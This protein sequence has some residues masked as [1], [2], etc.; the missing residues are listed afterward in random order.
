MCIRDRPGPAQTWFQSDLSHPNWT[1]THRS[2]WLAAGNCACG[3]LSIREGLINGYHSTCLWPQSIA[4]WL[5]GC[6]F[7]LVL[8]YTCFCANQDRVYPSLVIAELYSKYS[9]MVLGL[10]RNVGRVSRTNLFKVFFG[11]CNTSS[12]VGSLDNPA[13]PWRGIVNSACKVEFEP[14][15][16]G[17][18]VFF[19]L[20]RYSTRRLPAHPVSVRADSSSERDTTHVVTNLQHIQLHY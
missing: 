6:V 7:H 12:H 4:W 8:E 16:G 14:P 15:T 1:W 2:I 10:H 17:V 5:V 18:F 19:T 13:D 20:N 11:W 9:V 3:S